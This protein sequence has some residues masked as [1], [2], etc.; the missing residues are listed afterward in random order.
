MRENIKDVSSAIRRFVP[1]AMQVG[2]SSSVLS[3]IRGRN[4]MRLP[5]P[6][7]YVIDGVPYDVSQVDDFLPIEDVAE[8]T[9][10]RDGMGYGSRGANGVVIIRT[11]RGSDKR[12]Y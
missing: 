11:M 1:G 4:S 10:D 12:K 8:I 9:V 5:E 6:P 7:L 3:I 2:E